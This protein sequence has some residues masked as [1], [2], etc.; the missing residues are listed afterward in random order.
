MSLFAFLVFLFFV[1]FAGVFAQTETLSVA[2]NFTINPS[3][4]VI[5]QPFKA[6]CQ[7]LNLT[8]TDASY[9]VLFYR[10]YRVIANFTTIAKKTTI[11]LNPDKIFQIEIHPLSV[12]NLTS[13]EIFLVKRWPESYN[14]SCLLAASGNASVLSTQLTP[15]VEKAPTSVA[16]SVNVT[17]IEAE[18]PFT[19]ACTISN[20]DAFRRNYTVRFLRTS[21]WLGTYEIQGKLLS[22]IRQKN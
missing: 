20:Y 3:T 2:L 7:L 16:F 9:Q 15:P 22:L 19:G 10:N 21:G 4:V 11:Q 18:T 17:E 5:G 14:Y 8:P 6:K 12:F 13:F 1:F